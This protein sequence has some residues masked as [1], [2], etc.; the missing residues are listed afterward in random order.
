[1]IVMMMMVF[2]LL[3]LGVFLV[4]LFLFKPIND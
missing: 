1:M 3:Y 2:Y 4:F